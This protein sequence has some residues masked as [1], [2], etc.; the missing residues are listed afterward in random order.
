MRGGDSD[1]SDDDGIP[2]EGADIERQADLAQFERARGLEAL[3]VSDLEPAQ[4]AG[5]GGGVD[6]DPVETDPGPDD[7]GT[8]SLHRLLDDGVE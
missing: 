6:L 7:L 8:V 1:P 4:G 3:G 2:G 5:P